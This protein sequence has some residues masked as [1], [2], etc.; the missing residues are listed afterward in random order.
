MDNLRNIHTNQEVISYLDQIGFDV[1]FLPPNTTSCLQPLDYTVNKAVKQVYCELWG[2]WHSKHADSIKYAIPDF[3]INLALALIRCPKE[4]IF[5]SWK[6]LE[7]KTHV[8]Y[9]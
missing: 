9:R 6:C 3:Y 5:I 7:E 2:D 4:L 8:M 1:I